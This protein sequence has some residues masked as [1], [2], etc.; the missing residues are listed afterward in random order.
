MSEKTIVSCDVPGCL[1]CMPYT[2][3]RRLPEGWVWWELRTGTGTSTAPDIR[4]GGH[5]CPAHAEL[6]GAALNTLRERK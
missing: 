4:E 1:T 6:L 3:E 5:V 2:P